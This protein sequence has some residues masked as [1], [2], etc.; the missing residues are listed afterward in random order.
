[1]CGTSIPRHLYAF[2]LLL[3]LLDTGILLP[4]SLMTFHNINGRWKYGIATDPYK[5]DTM[6]HFVMGWG[7][8]CSLFL[9]PPLSPGEVNK[10]VTRF[11]NTRYV[12]M[13]EPTAHVTKVRDEI[14]RPSA[15]Q[16]N[17]M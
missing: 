17:N 13:I 14:A 10:Q 2:I 6:A 15:K 16:L 9:C 7:R 8:R 3:L 11:E 12:M 4:F 5:Y 1:M